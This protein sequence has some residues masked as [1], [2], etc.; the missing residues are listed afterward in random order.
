MLEFTIY[1]LPIK[2]MIPFST[3]IPSARNW[4]NAPLLYKT[5][6]TSFHVLKKVVSYACGLSYPAAGRVF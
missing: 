1:G 4:R 3:I 2:D 6:S 5:P